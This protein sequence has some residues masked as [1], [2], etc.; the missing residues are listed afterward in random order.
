MDRNLWQ[1]AISAVKA[2]LSANEA[3]RQLQA[4]GAGIRR[5]D[6]LAVH[7]EARA[8]L[9]INAKAYDRAGNRRP[10]VSETLAIET[11]TATG[12]LQHVDIW[13]RDNETGEIYARTYSIRTDELMTHDDAIETALDRYEGHAERYGHTILGAAYSATYTYVPR[14]Q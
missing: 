7:R 13:V 12:F 6:Y 9:A 3:L 10:Y 14:G 5:A 2:N 11:T 1:F 4:A 8:E